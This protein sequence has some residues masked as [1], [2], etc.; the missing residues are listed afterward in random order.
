ML[1]A[2]GI[3]VS[4]LLVLSLFLLAITLQQSSGRIPVDTF[5]VSVGIFLLVTTLTI[6]GVK[7]DVSSPSSSSLRSITTT[8][9]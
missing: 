9:G 5:P 3:N 2:E 1:I 8:R 6:Q 4:L 7:K